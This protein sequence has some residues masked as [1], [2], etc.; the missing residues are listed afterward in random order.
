M[1]EKILEELKRIE[2]EYEVKICL[3]VESG[4][5]A[6]GF[7]SKD[8][9][10]DV[11]FIY[12]HRPEWY[13]SIEQKRDV[14]ELP[15]N[16]LLDINGWELR[17]A[18]RLFKKSNPPL[19]E[20]LQSGIVY[21]QA[22]SLTDKMSTIQNKVFLPQ[23][24]LYHYLNMAKGN[25]RDYLQ[26]QYVKIK[27]YFYVLRPILACN[28]I[29]KH[30]SFPPIEFRELVEDLFE[31]GQ[32]KQEIL[33]LLERKMKGDELNLE[34]KITVINDFLEQEITRIENYTKT[35]SVERQDLT[36]LLDELF[37][38]TLTEIWGIKIY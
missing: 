34:P 10:Y 23:S 5:R 19:M 33:T 27:K 26:A 4:S 1:R 24:A 36:P 2:T 35:L 9:D 16:D 21:Y 29:E 8:S 25:Y 12:V 28:W 20:W 11:R 37:R 30:N 31:E 17:K 14:I 32:L 18:L 3:A 7:H 15:I 22:Y 38:D 6:W 13:L